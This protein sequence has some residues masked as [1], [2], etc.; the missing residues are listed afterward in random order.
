MSATDS[1]M[2]TGLL[3]GGLAGTFLRVPFVPPQADAIRVSGAKAAI[4][5]L[6][7]DGTNISRTGANVRAAADA[8]RVL[9][10]DDVPRHVRLR[11]GRGVEP[12]RLR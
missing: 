3:H 6:P 5:G 10:D 2:W 11:P 9:H 7:F 12:R 1:T 8:R 4:Y